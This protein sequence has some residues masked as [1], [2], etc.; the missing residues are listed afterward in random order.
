LLE[1]AVG[2]DS[3]PS[4]IG[5]LIAA[6]VRGLRIEHQDKFVFARQSGGLL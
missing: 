6:L 1:L 5:D 4:P 2:L 3:L